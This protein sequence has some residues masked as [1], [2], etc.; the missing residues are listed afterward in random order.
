MEG[1]ST[2]DERGPVRPALVAAAIGAVVWPVVPFTVALQTPSYAVSVDALLLLLFAVLVPRARGVALGAYALLLG[3]E[4]IRS[5][6]AVLMDQDPLL[7][8]LIYLLRHFA[9][10]GQDLLGWLLAPV[11][12]GV[13]LVAMIIASPDGLFGL[14]RKFMRKKDATA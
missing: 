11:V 9:V 14:V 2:S 3:W 6:G 8:D 4:V 10:L 5:T 13:V 1:P 12:L 7:Y